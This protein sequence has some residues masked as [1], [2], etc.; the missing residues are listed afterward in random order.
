MF[1]QYPWEKKNCCLNGKFT[2]FLFLRSVHLQIHNWMIFYGFRW[3]MQPMYWV[4]NIRY[5]A[6][7]AAVAVKQPLIKMHSKNSIRMFLLNDPNSVKCM[8]CHHFIFH[9]FWRPLFTK[10][11][12]NSIHICL[13]FFFHSI[14]HSPD[15]ASFIQKLERERE[16]RDHGEVKDH[17][18]FFAKYWMYIVPVAILVLVSGATSPDQGGSGG[19]R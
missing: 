9:L 12:T 17:R 15:T 2:R 19:G 3:I 7:V 16:A 4:Y 1:R 10:R 11:N 14:F 8:I 5:W 6:V 18:G 13:I